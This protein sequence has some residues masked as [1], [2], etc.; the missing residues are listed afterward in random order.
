MEYGLMKSLKIYS[1][2]LGILAGDYM[3]Q[4][5]DSNANMVGI[6]LLYRYGYF[7]QEITVSGEQRADYIPQKFSQLPLNPVFNE[8]GEWVKVSIAF[9]GRSVYAKAWRVNVGI[10]FLAV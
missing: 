3:K 9:P 8:N 4:A 10:I 7:A 1:G 6:G 2:G 5:S